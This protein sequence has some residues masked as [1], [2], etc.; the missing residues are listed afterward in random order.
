MLTS[1]AGRAEQV[2]G[3]GAL[4]TVPAHY[5]GSTPALTAAG[6]AH[7]A[8]GTLGVTLARWRTGREE[9]K[10]EFFGVNRPA[11]FKASRF[12]GSF[13][14]CMNVQTQQK[15]NGTTTVLCK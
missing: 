3:W 4:V 13:V 15:S 5:V 2:G 9:L 7:G 11:L 1:A 12:R 8:E 10:C 6:L 14:K